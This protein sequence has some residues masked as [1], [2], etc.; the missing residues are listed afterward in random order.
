ME[1]LDACVG[2]KWVL[3]E[4]DSDKARRLRDD[5]RIA[6]RDFAAPD[7]FA[8]ECAHALTKGER[9]GL[10]IDAGGLYDELRLDAPRFLSSIPVMARA[11]EI[12]RKARIAVYDC[13]Y[14]ALAEQERCKLITSDEKLIKNLQA[15]F[16]FIVS[17][18]SLPLSLKSLPCAF[19]G[20]ADLAAWRGKE[21]VLLFHFLFF[22]NCSDSR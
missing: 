14:V 19:D 4:I 3:D 9:K 7:L 10:I 1:I 18:S 2:L 21:G 15:D 11:V 6:L 20:S 5:F 16:P 8:A 12:A 13:V 17:L 22:L